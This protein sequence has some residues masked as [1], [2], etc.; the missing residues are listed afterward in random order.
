[1]A[2]RAVFVDKD[3]TLIKDDPY[4]VDTGRI[5]FYP[6]TYRSLRL[7]ASHGYN[8]IVVTNQPGVARG[9]FREVELKKVA[10]TL[11][12]IFSNRGIELSGFYYC[13]HDPDGTVEAYSIDCQCRKPNPGLILRAARDFNIDLSRSWM[14]GDILNDVEAGNRAGCRTI[15]VDRKNETEWKINE[16][17]KPDFIARDMFK[18]A[19]HVIGSGRFE[20]AKTAYSS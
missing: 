11:R 9:Y 1:M 12:G 17:R 3:G 15:M 8:I 13:P 16:W 19:G 7:M 18:A 2:S 10:S 20:V 4:N 5:E 6:E 14:I